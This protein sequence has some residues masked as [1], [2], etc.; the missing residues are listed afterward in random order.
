[1]SFLKPT[2]S[3]INCLCG[4]IFVTVDEPREVP[5]TITC[6]C[7]LE[8][9]LLPMS[10]DLRGAME[11]TAF[12]VEGLE[13]PFDAREYLINTLYGRLRS[14]VQ[15]QNFFAAHILQLK[16]EAYEKLRASS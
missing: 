4:E 1:M 15:N 11:D 7:G 13:F 10:G 14:A 16:I 3:V 6:K 5:D 9:K 2:D 12:I 8:L